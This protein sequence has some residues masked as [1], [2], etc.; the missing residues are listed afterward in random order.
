MLLELDL[1]TFIIALLQMGFMSILLSILLYN[2]FYECRVIIKALIFTFLSSYIITV[3]MGNHNVF[4]YTN[5]YIIYFLILIIALCIYKTK[6]IQ[7]FINLFSVFSIFYLVQSLQIL[8][9]RYLYSDFTSYKNSISGLVSA[10]S[11]NLC[12]L[13]FTVLV[14]IN[15]KV[16][17]AFRNY[18][19]FL[20]GS[21][22]FIVNIGIV[23][24]FIQKFIDYE[25][26]Y[27]WDNYYWIFLLI[28]ILF[29]LNYYGLK[30]NIEL[31]KEKSENEF[32]NKFNILAN[33]MLEDSR[34]KQHE[35]DNHLNTIY[36][37][38]VLNEDAKVTKNYIKKLTQHNCDIDFLLGIKNRVIAVVLYSYIGIMSDN[39]IDFKYKIEKDIA[40]FNIGDVELVELLNNLL[41]NSIEYL[42]N[43]NI[44]EKIVELTI[45]R[46]DDA[47]RIS[48]KNNIDEGSV[49][50]LTRIIDN[51][52]STKGENRGFGLK[53]VRS[54]VDDA[55][56]KVEII[57]EENTFQI[58]I[59]I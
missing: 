31:M 16:R 55:D 48:V 20:K 22:F 14:L 10:F 29:Y 2:K 50:N 34:R 49:T 46:I 59:I 7:T 36:S 41:N 25:R 4:G 1:N 54:I 19:K 45:S 11:I 56:G 53:N 26:D 5:R 40:I 12:L 6:T 57:I 3:L 52:K 9:F 15:L 58:E 8:I 17:K 42:S 21:P 47:I 35:F 23:I 37:M 28:V 24:I 43:V 39:K 51:G 27:I 44:D 38:I 18:T 33:K 30:K 13:V 32:N